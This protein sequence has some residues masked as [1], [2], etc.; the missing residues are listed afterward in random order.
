VTTATACGDPVPLGPRH[1]PAPGPRDPDHAGQLPGLSD[2]ASFAQRLRR[3]PVRVVPRPDFWDANWTYTRQLARLTTDVA[4]GTLPAFSF[5]KAQNDQS[6]PPGNGVSISAGERF[7][8]AVVDTVLGPTG[9]PS[10][11]YNV[12]FVEWNWLGG[13]TGQLDALVSAA[14]STSHARDAYANNLGDLL[15]PVLTGV[16]VPRTP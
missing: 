4:S 8:Q 3:Q 7:V 13:V 1:A 15:N 16:T 10:P 12:N 2:Y 11:A 9:S 6:E 14:G 5:V